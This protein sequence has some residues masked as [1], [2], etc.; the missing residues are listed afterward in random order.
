MVVLQEWQGALS[1]YQ[2][3]SLYAFLV[4]QVDTGIAAQRIEKEHLREKCKRCPLTQA[5]SGV[6]VEATVGLSVS[7]NYKNSWPEP[8]KTVSDDPN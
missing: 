3:I 5:V 8:Q 7:E 1:D 2:S 6:K 4:L